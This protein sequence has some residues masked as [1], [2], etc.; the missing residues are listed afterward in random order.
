MR[1]TPISAVSCIIID[2]NITK[3]LLGR[4]CLTHYLKGITNMETL[5]VTEFPSRGN[6]DSKPAPKV[7]GGVV[8]AGRAK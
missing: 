1:A 3:A 5:Q 2:N 7:G 4:V 8:V 6:W